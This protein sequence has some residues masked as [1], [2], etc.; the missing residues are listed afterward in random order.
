MPNLTPEI[1]E[2]FDREETVTYPVLEGDITVQ[3]GIDVVTGM[4]RLFADFEKEVTQNNF[5]ELTKK[6]DGLAAVQLASAGGVAT[7]FNQYVPE[8]SEAL[9]REDAADGDYARRIVGASLL[10][11]KANIALPLSDTNA[12]I[13]AGDKLE[14]ADPAGGLDKS[15]AT[16]NVCTAVE[17]KNANSGGVILVDLSGPIRVK[18]ATP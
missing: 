12:K 16:T 10:G 6:E 14:V 17:S 4:P 13:N 2:I 1:G 5:L 8:L 7:H 18:A 3:L 15:S 9:P 11:F